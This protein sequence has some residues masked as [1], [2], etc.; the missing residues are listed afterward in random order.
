MTYDLAALRHAFPALASGI[1]HFDGPGGTQVPQP[2]LDAMVG[3]LVNDNANITER[4]RISTELMAKDGI[5]VNDLYALM[6]PHPEFCA[7]GLHYKAEGKAMQGKQVA[8]EI[9]K[10]LPVK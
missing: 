5:P 4:N 7:D 10:V 1:A 2:V 6:L 8:A 3:Y 9:L